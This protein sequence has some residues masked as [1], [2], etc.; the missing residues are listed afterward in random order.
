MGVGWKQGAPFEAW[1]EPLAL[2]GRMGSAA[3]SRQQC[4]AAIG[5]AFMQLSCKSS[6]LLCARRSASSGTRTSGR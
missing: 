2:G 3:V 1:K 5:P 4:C 6:S